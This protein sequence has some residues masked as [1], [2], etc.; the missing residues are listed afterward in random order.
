MDDTDRTRVIVDTDTAGDDTQALVLAALSD[1]IELEGVTICAGNVE[2]TRQVENAKYT[3]QTAGV[4]DEVPVYEGAQDPL[5][6]SYDYA[7]YVHGE[8]GLGGSLFPQTGIPSGDMHAVKYIVRMARENPGEITV[9]A[10]APLTNLALA[11]QLEPELPELLDQVVC[12]GGAVNTLGNVTP[13]AEY[14][15]WV[16]PDA[17]AMVVDAFEITLIDWGVTVRDAELG[18]DTF[19]QIAQLDTELA[20]FYT[21]IIQPVRQF[22]HGA[23]DSANSNSDDNTDTDTATHPDSLT[24]ATVLDPDVIQTATRCY[25]N[26]DSRS[27]PTR[28]YT[29][30]DELDVLAHPAN[31]RV[32]KS[33]DTDRFRT[34]L[35]DALAHANPHQTHE[36]ESESESES[37]SEPEL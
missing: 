5:Q 23:T 26:V 11:L 29:L 18:S 28:G 35:L 27:G 32:I 33:I 12:M 34:I 14:N 10:I 31:A 22:T 7:D 36:P 20:S 2:F 19:E 30:A 6:K 17:A 13:A 3:L 1:R 21:T 8:G 4:A 37:E 25:I 15:F 16:D 9:V 24:M